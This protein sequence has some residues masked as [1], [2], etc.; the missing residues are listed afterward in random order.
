MNRR[1]GRVFA[2]R[3]I[4]IETVGRSLRIDGD[5]AGRRQGLIVIGPVPIKS[6][7]PDIARHIEQP[8]CVR[9]ERAYGSGSPKAV[10]EGI[11][12][13]AVPLEGIRHVLSPGHEFVSPQA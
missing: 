7:L 4:R 13:R 3:L 12:I 1:A 5:L 6:P 11:G 2:G 8:I 10:F 9:G